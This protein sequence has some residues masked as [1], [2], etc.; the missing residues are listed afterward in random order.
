MNDTIT[1]WLAF[2]TGALASG[3]IITQAVCQLLNY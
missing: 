2:I 3:A 1:I